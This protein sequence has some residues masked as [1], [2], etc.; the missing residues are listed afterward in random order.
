VNTSSAIYLYYD[1][2]DNSTVE[3]FVGVDAWKNS[4]INGKVKCLCLAN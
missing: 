1:A 4:I 2:N 3:Q